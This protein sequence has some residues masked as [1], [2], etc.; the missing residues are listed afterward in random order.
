MVLEAD[1]PRLAALKVDD[2]LEPRPE[3]GEVAGGAGVGPRLLRLR[4]DAGHFLDEFRRKLDGAI[5]GAADFAY[6]R[7]GVGV[8]LLALDLAEEFANLRVGDAFVAE[9]GEQ[10]ELLG[11][12]GGAVARHVGTLVPAQH[13]GTGAEHPSFFP[14]AD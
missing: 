8:E 14:A 10:R 1:R 7:R 2:F 5:V 12:V 4:G 9:A 13:R 11:P 3:A 6:I